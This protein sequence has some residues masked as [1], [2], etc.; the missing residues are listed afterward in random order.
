MFL[1]N[2]QVVAVSS[3]QH[4]NPDRHGLALG[5]ADERFL[6]QTGCTFNIKTNAKIHQKL[7]N[8]FILI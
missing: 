1:Q 8:V 6:T 2:H 7:Q 4:S 3:E 5:C